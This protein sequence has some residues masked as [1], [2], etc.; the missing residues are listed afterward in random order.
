M[1]TDLVSVIVPVYNAESY[2]EDCIKSL[3][4]Q[5]YEP[6][7]IVLVDDG[8]TDRSGEICWEW[9]QRHSR[10]RV[11]S[12]AHGGQSEARNMALD[13]C[14]GKYIVFAD[15]DDYTEPGYVAYLHTLISENKADLAV[16]EF[17][18][19]TSGGSYLNRFADDGSVRILDQK[20][21]LWELCDDRRI[22]CS[23]CAK[24][25][26]A[27][28]F[29]GIRFPEGHIFEDIATIYKLFLKAERVAFG[30]RALYHYI[31]RERSTGTTAFDVRRM[32]SVRYAHQM[33]SA[34]VQKW[35]EL[36]SIAQ[37]RLFV[38][39][40]HCMRAMSISDDWSLGIK[41]KYDHLYQNIKVL[42]RQL[43]NRRMTPK[44]N[45]YVMCS[46]FGKRVLRRGF[47]VEAEIY[48][49]FRLERS[50]RWRKL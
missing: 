34:I 4:A 48:R 33:C 24:I 43:P 8:S 47:R 19:V 29:R 10:I 20:Q 17:R 13:V 30:S 21:A 50:N 31:R 46:L 16:C 12:K 14:K 27:E 36:G 1:E 2:L 41:E 32:D 26:S 42:R 39:Y 49:H 11:L 25:F 28:A 15:A 3:V 18:F 6:L 40:A 7:E 35:P 38:E 22:S 23:P 45:Y 5:T 37:K 9:A 44:Q